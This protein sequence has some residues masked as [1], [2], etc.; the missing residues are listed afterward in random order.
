M[1]PRL[2]SLLLMVSIALPVPGVR[3]DDAADKHFT[4]RVLP[5]LELRCISCHGPDK[6][7]GGLRMDSREDLL[8]GGENGPAVVPGKPNDSLLLQVVTHSKKDLEM[9]PKEKLTTNDIALLE[10]WIADGAPWPKSALTASA[11]QK[12]PPGERLGD[13]WHDARNPIV[14]IFGGQRLDLCPSSRFARTLRRW[15]GTN[16]GLGI[17]SINSFSSVSKRRASPLPL[18]RTSVRWRGGSTSI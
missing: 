17:P 3:A 18:R 8:T 11:P 6:V 9:P 16:A 1:K 15:C 4:A 10:K 7:K 12:L 5:L 2:S 14:R 13:A